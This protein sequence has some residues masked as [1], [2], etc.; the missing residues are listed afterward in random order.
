MLPNYMF[1]QIQSEIPTFSQVLE[2][3]QIFH[4]LNK[5]EIEAERFL[6]KSAE[7]FVEK[8]GSAGN[9]DLSSRE[10]TEVLHRAEQMFP[11][12]KPGKFGLSVHIGSSIMTSKSTLR[13][14]DTR[15]GNLV[16]VK[17]R[18][19][20]GDQPNNICGTGSIIRIVKF[21]E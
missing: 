20:K 6:K 18:W 9:F 7:L 4:A 5:T 1:L 16:Y 21:K 12:E 13:P 14:F 17:Q 10:V 15:L 19:T 2:R 11:I 3:S 8:E